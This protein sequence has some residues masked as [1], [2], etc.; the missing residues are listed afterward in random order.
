[1]LLPIYHADI[2]SRRR[3]IR[4]SAIM[5]HQFAGVPG[6]AHEDA[7]TA[8]EEDRLNAYYAAGLL[9]SRGREGG[10]IEAPGLP[11]AF[12]HTAVRP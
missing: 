10:L 7:I 4:V 6:H 5:A 3:T 2:N 12:S 9:Y 8:R 11:A 1:V